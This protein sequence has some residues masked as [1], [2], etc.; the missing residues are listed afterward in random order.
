MV[1][2]EGAD[3]ESEFC[4]VCG[5]RGTQAEA[6]NDWSRRCPGCGAWWVYDMFPQEP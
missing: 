2:A 5:R 1:E 6:G 4:P 3:V